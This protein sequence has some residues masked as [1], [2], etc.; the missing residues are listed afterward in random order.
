MANCSRWASLTPSACCSANSRS[1]R[2]ISSGSPPNGKNPPPS[3]CGRLDQVEAIRGLDV[4]PE[5]V[6]DLRGAAHRRRERRRCRGVERQLQSAGRLAERVQARWRRRAAGR[7]ARAGAPAPRP[8]PP[9]CRPGP[10]RSG[11]RRAARELVEVARE[12]GL[13]ATSQSAAIDTASRT[14][15]R[16]RSGRPSPSSASQVRAPAAVSNAQTYTRSPEAGSAAST[17]LTTPAPS[18]CDAAAAAIRSRS[19]ARPIVPG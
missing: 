2:M 7:R 12:R 10:R 18:A 3:I 11:A 6:R 13:S 8:R 4:L 5:R 15:R 16:S 19:S 14:S 1:P 17:P 9:R